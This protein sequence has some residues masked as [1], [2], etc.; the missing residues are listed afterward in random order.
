LI[1]SLGDGANDVGALKQADVGVALLTGFGDVNVDK[2]EDA[3][4]KK[5]E[6][7]NPQIPLTAIMTEDQIRAM[8]MVPPAI[9]KAK[10][11][12]LGVNPDKY[13]DIIEKEDLIKLYQIKAR[14]KAVKEHDK[15]V[16]LSKNKANRS[17]LMAEKQAKMQERI[18]E[19]EAQGE[20]WAQFKAMKE[21]WA[22][23]MAEGK[24]KKA[25]MAKM[26]GVEGQAA[27]LTAQLEG[28]ELE[29]IPM[30][31]LGDA[32]IAA[33]FTSKMPSIRSCVDIVRQG[34]CTLVTSMQMVSFYSFLH[35]DSIMSSREPN[36]IITNIHFCCLVP[37]SCTQL[38]D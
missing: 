12:Q 5:E 32:S 11:R 13:P 3:A 15:K 24:K 22:E 16:A 25:N 6:K 33:P 1:L 27:N 8:R 4:K 28:L 37:N 20:P 26:G 18:K 19:L 9:I 21:F 31:K 35:A 34:R 10:I 38:Y 17:E 30:V 29:E 7:K 2:G 36:L 23:E 14:E